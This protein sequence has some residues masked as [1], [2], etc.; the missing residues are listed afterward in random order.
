MAYGVH[1]WTAGI[2]YGTMASIIT[3]LE[4]PIRSL[5]VTLICHAK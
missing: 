2:P 4:V 5:A 3:E 1:I